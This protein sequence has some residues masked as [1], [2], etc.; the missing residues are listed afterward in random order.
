MTGSEPF[1]MVAVFADRGHAEMAIDELNHAGFAPDQV[2]IVSPDGDV[3]KAHTSTQASEENASDGA[4]AGAIS[5][6]V[7][8]VVAGAVATVLIPGIGAVVAGGMF[9]AAL[10]GGAAGAAGGSYLGPFIAMG[11]SKLDATAFEQ[12]LRSGRTL[13]TVDP[14]ERRSAAL[15]ILRAHAGDLLS[16]PSEKSAALQR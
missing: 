4:V 12:H 2:G 15:Q 5:G 8:G 6:G 7:A 14:G 3:R 10:L 16:L 1:A 13:V 11:F 9:T